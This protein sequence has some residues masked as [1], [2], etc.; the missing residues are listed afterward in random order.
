MEYERR[1][2]TGKQTGWILCFA[3]IRYHKWSIEHRHRSFN[4][5]VL[6]RVDSS[7]VWWE[8]F[9]TRVVWIEACYDDTPQI[10][11]ITYAS[12]VPVNI[13]HCTQ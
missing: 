6:K 12:K 3:I 5:I 2:T 7:P 13:N 11:V 1:K 9:K 10:L 8:N 4:E